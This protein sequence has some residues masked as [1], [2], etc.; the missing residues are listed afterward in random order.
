MNIPMHLRYKAGGPLRRFESI[1]PKRHGI[2]LASGH[3]AV[4]GA[5]TIFPTTVNEVGHPR[6]KRLLKSGHNS[7]KIGKTVTKGK[8]KGFPIFTLTLEER[9]TCPRTCEVFESC[10]GNGMPYAQRI[11]HGRAFEEALWNELADKQAAHPQGFLVRLHILGD[12]YS[13]DYAELWAEALEAYPALH[14][15][16]YTA[17]EPQSDIGQVVCQMLGVWP[18]RL[19][20][21]FSGWGGGKE[22]VGSHRDG[23]R[24]P[25]RRLP[26]PDRQDRLL[27][28]MRA[29]LAQRPHHRLPEALSVT[30]LPTIASIQ[31]AV[32][33][34]FGVPY[35]KMR[36]PFPLGRGKVYLNKW[37][38]SRP[39]QVAMALA[40]L[41]TD[42]GYTRI[43]HFFGGR[44]PATVRHAAAIV[45]ERR[46]IDRVLHNRMRRISLE[47]LRR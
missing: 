42:H 7:R 5:R 39:R 26:G 37:E 43:G 16:G 14:V 34:E 8:L 3:A 19:H 47:L 1:A 35:A 27:R 30:P 36:E 40:V 15:F 17:R 45:A 33:E 46:R 44:D 2:V 9:A 29:V 18:E 4:V 12:F 10:Y 24:G 32:A 20:V 28:D 25:T 23:R 38:V 6:L 41:L 31:R 22:R 11:A 21:R 13:A